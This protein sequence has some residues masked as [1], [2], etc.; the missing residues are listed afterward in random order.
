MVFVADDL[1]SWLVGALADAGRR[2]LITWA[3][4]SDQE[5]ALKQAATAAVQ[6]T[7]AELYPEEGERAEELAMVVNQVFSTPVPAATSAGQETLLEAIQ[8]GVAGQLA[9]LGD[10]SL[11]GTGRSSADL[12]GVS[13]GELAQKLTG[14]LV[15]EVMIR[16]AHGGPLEP[17]AAQLNHDVTHLQAQRLEVMVGRIANELGV[18]PDERGAMSPPARQAAGRSL[19]EVTDP[20]ALEVHRPV[21]LED[22]Q[23]H[24]PLLPTY[25]PRSHDAEL[26][27]VVHVAAEGNSRIAVLVGGSS[28]GKT[29]ACWEALHLLRDQSPDWRLWHP[30]DPSRPSALLRG[31]PDIKPRTVVWLNEAQLYLDI[32]DRGLGEQVAAGLRELL[33]DPARSPVLVLATMWPA[34]WDTLTSRPVDSPDPHAQAREL[35]AAQD[36]AVPGA[37]TAAQLEHLSRSGDERLAAAATGAQNGQVAQFLAGVPGLLARYRYAPPAARALIHAAMDARRMGMRPTLPY[38][39]LELAAPGYLTD[40]EWD[41]LAEDWLEQALAYT[42]ASTM[43]IPGP[44]TRIRPRPDP[45]DPSSIRDDRPAYQLADYLDQIGR[46]DRRDQIPPASFWA[47]ATGNAHP[48]DLATLGYAAQSRGLYR[49]AAQLLKHAIAG[50]PY[51]APDLINNLHSLHPADQR[52]AS[53]I[54]AHVAVKDPLAVA[55][56]LETLQGMDARKQIATLA[57]RATPYT[58]LSNPQ[59]VAELL[60]A[61]RESGGERQI[62]TL[63][64]RDP[65]SH[66]ATDDA[67][68]ISSLLDELARAGAQE[69]AIKLADRAVAQVPLA[70]PDRVATLLEV[71]RR[72]HARTHIAALL[73]RDPAAHATLDDTAAAAKLLDAL[74]EVGASEQVTSLANRAAAAVPLHDASD[75]AIMLNRL[76]GA[77]AA[78][79]VTM[80][81]GRNPAAHVALS[82]ARGLAALLLALRRAGAEEQLTALLDHDLAAHVPLHHGGLLTITREVAILLGALQE[83]GA[84]GQFTELADRAAAAIP[85]RSS[86]DAHVLL[87]ELRKAGQANK[88]LNRD[89]ASLADPRS[90]RNLLDAVLEEGGM[91]EQITA[92]ADRAAAAPID[93]PRA[94]AGLLYALRRAG[95]TAQAAV[96]AD[97]AAAVSPLNDPGDVAALLKT[98]RE[99]GTE[100]QVTTLLSRDPAARTPLDNSYH[101]SQLLEALQEAGAQDQ[102]R[103]LINRLPGEGFFDVWLYEGNEERFRFGREADGRPA[104]PWAWEDLD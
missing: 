44:L 101:A 37:F 64:S 7:A 32:P 68:S 87:D 8:A 25:V 79:Q 49:V 46:S 42:A 104:E 53:W 72:H 20:F 83:V 63:L 78:E 34:F 16:G 75:V 41:Q 61:L 95:A 52:P 45:R 31:L 66:V 65:A 11:T 19:S 38:A 40:Y 102:A 2:R 86:I 92:L 30:I 69:Q 70:D 50:D 22:P 96:L 17:L 89:P 85:L 5:H 15:G 73:N 82:D 36:I 80:L 51:P 6:L 9:V 10:A 4:G 35:L 24:L 18:V 57:D 39:F 47:A 67:H 88:L 55:W 59:D 28:T 103:L 13:A 93:D 84:W 23:N 97:R 81:L 58:A 90:I 1:A 43:G 99:V 71:L 33:R 94:V 48:G 56:L 29:R 62:V 74:Q 14:H 12:L 77:G 76:S 27:R 26:S 100:A 98:L 3:R 54:A 91:G 60:E 21:E